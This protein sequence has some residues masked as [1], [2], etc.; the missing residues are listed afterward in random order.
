MHYPI[1]FRNTGA[2]SCTLYGFPG[3]S[4]LTADGSQI[5]A[6]AQRQ[7]GV[8]LVTVTLAPG[9]SAYS[10]VGVTDPGIPPCSSA[11]TA[12]QVRVFPPGQTQSLLV[13]VPTGIQV[14]ASANTSTYRSAI[15]TP[16]TATSF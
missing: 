16:M 13:A 10:S 5:G 2:S 12:T 7:S 15:V 6:P 8:P 1:D 4:F 9:A 11:S 14:C 3:V